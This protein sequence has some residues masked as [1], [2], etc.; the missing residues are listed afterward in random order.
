MTTKMMEETEVG[1]TK[2][3]PR[4]PHHVARRGPEPGRGSLSR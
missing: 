1:G 4:G 3:S 2:G